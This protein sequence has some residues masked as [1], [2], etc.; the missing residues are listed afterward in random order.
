MVSSI[1]KYSLTDLIPILPLYFG[2]QQYDQLNIASKVKNNILITGNQGLPFELAAHFVHSNSERGSKPFS[3]VDYIA[4]TGIEFEKVLFGSSY[5]T[6]QG[7]KK[8]SMGL[9]QAA[10]GGSLYFSDLNI[11]SLDQQLAIMNAVDRGYFFAVGSKE[12]ITFDTRIIGKTDKNIDESLRKGIFRKDFYY[13]IATITI[14]LASLMDRREDIPALSNHLLR[15]IND[16]H[17]KS[18]EGLTEEACEILKSFSWVGEIV[19]LESV[20]ERSVIFCNSNIITYS[21]LPDYLKTNFIA[22]TYKDKFVTLKE[23][24]DEFQKHFINSTLKE[25]LFDKESAA[26]QLGVG[27]STLYRKMEELKI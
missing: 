17:G 23:A 12:P 14:S 8:H 10:N 11:L 13:W 1:S 25:C 26:V 7:L 4:D 3:I 15:T 21:H 19:Q 6:P 24:T 27:L 20:I 22:E 18:I 5:I 2:K 9:L 16:K